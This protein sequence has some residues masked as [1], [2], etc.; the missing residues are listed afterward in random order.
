MKS[1]ISIFLLSLIFMPAQVL[2]GG[3]VT[4]F[5]WLVGIPGLEGSS[6]F[7]DYINALYALAISVAAL[8]AVVKIIIAGAKYMMSDIVSS[9]SEA[10]EDI[11]NSLIGLLIIIGAV[12]ILNTVNSNLTNVQV[13]M[14]PGVFDDQPEEMTLEEAVGRGVCTVANGCI[15]EPCDSTFMSSV[16]AQ[17]SSCRQR[18]E[19][20]NGF[21]NEVILRPR[22]G[23]QGI[24]NSTCALTNEQRTAAVSEVT[25]D[26]V[27]ES[28]PAGETCYAEP[29]GDATA[30]Y[31][32]GYVSCSRAC[33][34]GLGAG[35]GLGG[36][37]YDPVTQACIFIRSDRPDETV[38]CAAGGACI[39][40]R[41]AC[42]SDGGYVTSSTAN[43]PTIV[44]RRPEEYVP[45]TA[46]ETPVEQCPVG[47]TMNCVD[48]VCVCGT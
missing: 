4:G 38:T 22:P 5:R 40:E 19:S 3:E 43:P 34:G 33:T 39:A 7:E 1:I 28:C 47:Q 20:L 25:Q 11:R 35:N 29:C 6:N 36:A 14:E 44:C 45:P 18:C 8:I 15:L 17:G 41:N 23:G 21:Y 37:A 42:S 10:K 12:I 24:D 31:G 48:G 2:A 30:G 26:L 27:R 9:K 13:T 46:P 16:G 32:R